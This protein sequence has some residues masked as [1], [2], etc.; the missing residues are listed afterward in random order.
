[1]ANCESSSKEYRTWQEI[2]RRCAGRSDSRFKYYGGRGIRV[3]DEWRADFRAF[4]AYVGRAPSAAHSI[5]RIN[6]DGHYEPGNVRWATRVEQSNNRRGRLHITIGGIT[7]TLAEWSHTSGVKSGTIRKRLCS[8]VRGTR[9][10]ADPLTYYQKRR[11]L[12]INGE[13]KSLIEWAGESGLG[14][15]MIWRRSLRGWP[16]DRLLEP[17]AR[18]NVRPETLVEGV[19]GQMFVSACLK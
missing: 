8:G 11:M 19:R 14:P 16:D 2:K 18:G 1:M 17:S 5:D 4:L 12:T 3:C 9:L 15:E 13:T 10:L 6:N 7:K